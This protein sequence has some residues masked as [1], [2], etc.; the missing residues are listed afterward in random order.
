MC[1]G[2]DG[3]GGEHA[4][5]IIRGPAVR[6]LSD[7]ALADVIHDGIPQRGMPAF[8]D[9]GRADADSI[10]AYLRFLQ[11]KASGAPVAGDPDQGRGL[12]FAKAG[13]SNCHAFSGQGRFVAS[14]LTDFA[15][16]HE[17]AEIRDS[18]LKP[19][20]RGLD[21]ATAVA[22][23]GGKFSGAVRNEDNTS[24]QLQD[25]D[26]RF[27]LLMKSTLVSVERH[28]GARMPSDYGQR[29]SPAEID[30]LVAFLVAKSPN[31]ESS[32][33]DALPHGED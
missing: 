6:D 31:T 23:D 19:S 27:D 25:G 10:V 29:L 11:G 26:G 12:F 16:D 4:P 22:R 1:H 24:L 28:A 8:S 30:D 14:D 2:L 21:I 5:N 20:G 15:R 3:Q 32:R 18:I 7:Q 9:L 33:K 17:P 13:C